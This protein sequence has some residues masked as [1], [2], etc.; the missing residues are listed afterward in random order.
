MPAAAAACNG[1]RRPPPT[2]A[3]ASLPPTRAG[4]K[5]RA[6]A[7]SDLELGRGCP[8]D[9]AAGPIDNDDRRRRLQR[10]AR[11]AGVGCA[12]PAVR[13]AGVRAYSIAETTS[14]ATRLD[15]MIERWP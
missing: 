10:P 5:E 12:Y 2:T 9:L 15:S 1:R 7:S 13:V 4:M 11:V 6:T 14:C 3:P 8:P